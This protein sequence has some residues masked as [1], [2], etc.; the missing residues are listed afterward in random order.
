MLHPE[1]FEDEA[2]TPPPNTPEG[3]NTQH[4]ALSVLADWPRRSTR[5]DGS[6]TSDPREGLANVRRFAREAI[7][8][9]DGLGR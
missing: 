5:A 3:M 1:W 8:A 9:L 2:E 6:L 7:Q 4:E